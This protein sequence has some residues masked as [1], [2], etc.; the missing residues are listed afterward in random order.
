M[1]TLE[2]AVGV[3]G[4]APVS[5]ADTVGADGEDPQILMLSHDGQPDTRSPRPTVR[6]PEGLPFIACELC[7]ERVGVSPSWK[8]SPW[9]LHC[10][11]SSLSPDVCTTPVLPW[12]LFKHPRNRWPTGPLGW[13]GLVSHGVWASIPC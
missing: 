3:F 11:S 6:V 2:T 12:P 8:P 9:P 13:I 4:G 1:R 5:E 7:R 10:A